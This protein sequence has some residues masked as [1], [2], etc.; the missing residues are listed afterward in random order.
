MSLSPP[1]QSSRSQFCPMLL[2]SSG[3]VLLKGLQICLL[4]ISYDNY[5]GRLWTSSGSLHLQETSLEILAAYEGVRAVSE[6]VGTEAQLLLA[7]RL[8]VLGWMFKERVPSMHHAIDATWSKWVALSTQWARMGNPSHPGILEVMMDW[9]EDKD[10]GLLP[11]EEVTRAE[12]APLYNKLPEDKKQY[13]LF[14]DGS[15]RKHRKFRLNTRKNFF[16]LREQA[17]QGS[18]GVS[19]SGDIQ[20]PPGQG[21][22]QPTVGDPAS[23]GGLD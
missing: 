6:V 20:D 7:P 1:P 9:P 15:C 17:A 14:M 12:E 21:A 18:C 22:L 11:E 13:A 8:L 4:L 10:F 23:A 2:E 19:F 3:L 5:S 16:P